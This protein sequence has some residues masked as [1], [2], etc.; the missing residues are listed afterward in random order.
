MFLLVCFQSA[1][2]HVGLLEWIT[3]NNSFANRVCSFCCTYV[4]LKILLHFDEWLEWFIS[5]YSFAACMTSIHVYCNYIDCQIYWN[6][7]ITCWNWFPN[8]CVYISEFC[9]IWMNYSFHTDYAWIM[10]Q[11][12]SASSHNSAW[13]QIDYIN[14]H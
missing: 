7:D 12:D 10:F 5:Q 2:F 4:H 6:S 14:M 8:V 13:I 3:S 1:Y 9:F 11:I